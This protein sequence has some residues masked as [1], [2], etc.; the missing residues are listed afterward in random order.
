MSVKFLLFK[1][2]SCGYTFLGEI[3]K[4]TYAKVYRVKNREGY[5][6]AVKDL[7]PYRSHEGIPSI[8]E[9]DIMSRI[10]SSAL[11]T[12]TEILLPDRK[13]P[14][15]GVGLVQ[16]LA[17]GNLLDLIMN[18]LVTTPAKIGIMFDLA[19]ALA[20]LHSYGILHLDIKLENVLYQ[21]NPHRPKVLLSDFGLSQYVDDPIN[22]RRLS[23]ELVTIIYRPPE[24]LAQ[25]DLYLYTAKTDIWSLGILFLELLGNNQPFWNL[26][27][28]EDYADPS[29][30]R[31]RQ[32]QLFQDSKFIQRY[33]LGVGMHP[34]VVSEAVDLLSKMLSLDPAKRATISEVLGSSIFTRRQLTKPISGY[35]VVVPQ[36]GMGEGEDSLADGVARA[37]II[38]MGSI[39]QIQTYLV[40]T[41]FLAIDLYQRGLLIAP[42]RSDNEID[43]INLSAIAITAIRIAVKMM[44]DNNEL[45]TEIIQGFKLEAQISIEFIEEME[46]R[47]VAGF[48]GILYR[49]Y[50]YT[51]IPT[52][53]I[54]KEAYPILTNTQYYLILDIPAWIGMQRVEDKGEDKEITVEEYLRM[55]M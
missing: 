42:E 16:P 50:L 46:R 3:G 52:R 41:L 54:L 13:C 29:K 39:R 8:N 19:S 55:V 7:L 35:E 23:I 14:L 30:L 1:M 2:E 25:K 38:V 27:S 6:Y 18:R 37:L 48:G 40:T 21:G 43:R 45:L 15:E 17:T 33:L 53:A 10:K 51:A 9:I 28:R 20:I 49:R 26:P 24:L 34:S 44:Y 32:Y 12:I 11:M 5:L 36:I 31:T 22:G 4:G 47:M